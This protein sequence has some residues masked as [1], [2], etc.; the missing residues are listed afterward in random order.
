[1]MKSASNGVDLLITDVI[2]PEIS[3]SELAAML[4][5]QQPGLRVLYISGYADDVLDRHGLLESL[6]QF[7]QKPFMPLALASK[8]REIL[9]G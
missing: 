1:M 7:I 8:V 6:D 2:M 4:R 5:T 3:G 9:N